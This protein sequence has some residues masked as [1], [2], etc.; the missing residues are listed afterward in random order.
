VTT[1]VLA[2]VQSNP[3]PPSAFFVGFLVIWATFALAMICSIVFGVFCVIDI[4]GRPDWQWSIARQQKTLWLCLVIIVNLAVFPLVTSF[5]Y[6]F[7]VRR[8]LEAV[9]AAAK[10]G[11]FGPGYVTADGWTPWPPSSPYP[12]GWLPDPQDPVTLRYWDGLAW[13]AHTRARAS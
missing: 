9:E 5:I 3:G 13:T 11:A 8:K 12:P 4:M 7:S 2:A 10:A 6:W 1:S